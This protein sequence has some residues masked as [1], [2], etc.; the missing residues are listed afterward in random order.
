MFGETWDQVAEWGVET[1][2]NIQTH[3]GLVDCGKAPNASKGRRSVSVLAPNASKGWRNTSFSAEQVEG[4]LQI[5][6][7][8][9]NQDTGAISAQVAVLKAQLAKPRKSNQAKIDMLSEE[10]AAARARG[11]GNE[12]TRVKALKARAD[13]LRNCGHEHEPESQRSEKGDKQ[14]P[15]RRA[16]SARQLV[17]VTA[18]RATDDEIIFQG[19]SF[20]AEGPGSTGI[21]RSLSSESSASTRAAPKS[22]RIQLSPGF[23]ARSAS[24]RSLPKKKLLPIDRQPWKISEIGISL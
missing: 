11:Y 16:A 22:P 4:P 13:E 6:A 23:L 20:S 14:N 5:A 1:V 7:I 9:A 17:S 24:Q 18:R 15:F 3:V 21:H 2:K 10:L 8:K 19:R 12:S